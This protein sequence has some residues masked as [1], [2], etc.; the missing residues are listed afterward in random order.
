MIN[1]NK[2]DVHWIVDPGHIHHYKVENVEEFLKWVE[3]WEV[4]TLPSGRYY[5]LKERIHFWGG[6]HQFCF[7][8]ETE[9]HAKAFTDR[10]G[11]WVNWDGKPS[12]TPGYIDDEGRFIRT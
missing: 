11:A 7:G 12:M 10:W 2:E 3:E 9:E 8:V 1:L 4:E 6:Q 5:R